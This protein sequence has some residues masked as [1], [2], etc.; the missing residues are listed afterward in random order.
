MNPPQS[1]KNINRQSAAASSSQHISAPQTKRDKKDEKGKKAEAKSRPRVLLL[2][3]SGNSG[4]SQTWASEQFAH[5]DITS[6]NKADLKWASKRAALANLRKFSPQVFSV[7]TTDL[8]TQNRLAA[9]MLFAVIAGASQVVLGDGGGNIVRRSRLGVLLLE[10]PRLAL[11]LL[12]GYVL[13]IPFSWLLTEVLGIA[14]YFRPIVRASRNIKVRPRTSMLALYIRAT[15]GNA[16]EGG[17]R[18]HIAGFS[19]GAIALGHRLKFIES[20]SRRRDDLSISIEPSGAFG[21]T[22]ALFELWNNLVFTAKSVAAE[23][24]SSEEADFIYQRYSRFNWTGVILSMMTGRPLAVEFNGSEVWVSRQW[25]PVGQL[26]LLERF[27]R[28]NLRAADLIFVVSEVE[29]RNLIHAGVRPEKIVVNANGVNTD[30]FRPECGGSAVRSDLGIRAK[31]VVGFVG[32]FGPWHGAPVLAESARLVGSNTHFHFLFVGDGDQRAQ[33]ESIVNASGVSATFTGRMSHEDVP[34]YLDACDILVSPHVRATDGSEFF[35]SPTKVFEYLS[36]AKPVIASRLGQVAD[37]IRDNKNGLLVE[38][39]DPT[40][41]ARAIERL[42][43]DETLRARLGAA[44][45]QTVIEQYTW[46]QNA[47]RVFDAMRMNL[48]LAT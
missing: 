43:L 2:D 24:A 6:I 42:A 38:P 35:G 36:M 34:A 5:A 48:K 7:F 15:L 45:R 31:T 18:T 25:D 4:A 27:E 28:L 44:G 29:R 23:R 13:I 32:T 12:T 33:T 10:A 3:L 11:E 17:M 1:H 9:L 22:K 30:R 37:V 40:A 46:R 41:L 8:R 26:W 47:A 39:G 19:S 21:A 20:G 16:A 14:L